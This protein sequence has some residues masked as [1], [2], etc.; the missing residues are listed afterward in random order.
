LLDQQF[1][2]AEAPAAGGY[3]IHAGFGAIC[4]QHG[5][6]GQALQQCAPRDVGGEFVDGKTGLNVPDIG[7]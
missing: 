5:T 4:I 6:N 1:Q 7:L 3:L 2:R